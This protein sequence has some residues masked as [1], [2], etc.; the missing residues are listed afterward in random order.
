MN[1]Q[2]GFTPHYET[3]LMALAT[4]VCVITQCGPQVSRSLVDRCIEAPSDGRVQED[5]IINLN[6]FIHLLRSSQPSWS[7]HCS[8]SRYLTAVYVVRGY[9]AYGVLTENQHAHL[10]SATDLCRLLTQT[11]HHTGE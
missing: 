3:A 11:F 4:H 2:S 7:I 1:N 8:T 6:E 10:M 9:I 5:A